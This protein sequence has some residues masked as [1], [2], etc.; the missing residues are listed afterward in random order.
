MRL[1]S[2]G[3]EYSEAALN[4]LARLIG[5]EID[6]INNDLAIQVPVLAVDGDTTPSV[7][8][9][10]KNAM[11]VLQ[12]PATT[13]YTVTNFI[14]GNNGQHI[15]VINTGSSSFTISRDNA[16]LD[17]G[18]NK[19]IA[20]GAVIQLVLINDEWRQVAAVMGNS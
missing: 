11:G 14:N 10:K 7:R 1:P 18:S 20:A 4:E 15:A 13:N 12:V 19:T 6:Q 5:L 17:S 2:F 3:A 16:Q 9:L 8:N